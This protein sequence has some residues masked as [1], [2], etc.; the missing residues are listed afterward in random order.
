MHPTRIAALIRAFLALLVMIIISLAAYPV[1]L[2]LRP[3]MD[4][5]TADDVKDFAVLA[6]FILFAFWMVRVILF[7]PGHNARTSP[8]A[9]Q[10][11][12]DSAAA[13]SAGSASIMSARYI[14]PGE[15]Q[16]RAL[17]RQRFPHAD[18]T[19]IDAVIAVTDPQATT[20]AL[21][22]TARMMHRPYSRQMP[23]LDIQRISEHEVAHAI[24]AH[25]LT[26]VVTGISTSGD[27][28]GPN[29]AGYVDITHREDLPTQDAAYLNAMVSAAGW[30]Q[31]IH[32]ADAHDEGSM[33]DLTMLRNNLMIILST[34]RRPS[35]Y[36]GPLDEGA[37]RAHILEQTRA[38]LEETRAVR[39]EL[40]E[41]LRRDRSLSG[42]TFNTYM[43]QAAAQSA[44]P[45]SPTARRIIAAIDH[46]D[47]I[48]GL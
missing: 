25:Q 24:L 16:H 27:H 42:R 39:T 37:L 28:K 30:L 22:Q 38:I 17:L 46:H 35:G 47:Q 18:Q 31:D 33:S 32:E 8:R 5:I 13:G 34:D 6:P 10:M 36:E 41:L 44:E 11:G 7:N 23:T 3:L 2:W 26:L 20:H 21:L 15:V 48:T 12:P 40:V 14:S 9:T 43:R 45:L 1:Y 4:Q 29:V 19:F